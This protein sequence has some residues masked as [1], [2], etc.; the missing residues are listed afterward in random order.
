MTPY[1]LL[2]S[3]FIFPSF[4]FSQTTTPDRIRSRQEI[5]QELRNGTPGPTITNQNRF[6]WTQNRRQ[7][8]ESQYRQ[9]I[10]TLSH[11]LDVLKD[12]KIRIQSRI[13][14]NQGKDVDGARKKMIEFTELELAYGQ[15]LNQLEDQYQQLVSADSPRPL[16][17]GLKDTYRLLLLDLKSL[18][19][20]LIDALH[21]LVQGN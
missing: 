8:L 3:V 21:Y 1:F 14:A 20:V 4:A 5:R 17:P 16:L 15:H 2:L 13:Q 11:R 6:T 12:Y 19:Q 10:S 7:R 18:R 9:M